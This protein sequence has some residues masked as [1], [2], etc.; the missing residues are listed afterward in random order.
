[1]PRPH[2]PLVALS[3]GPL[4]SQPLQAREATPLEAL[5]EDAVA[6]RPLSLDQAPKLLLRPAPLLPLALEPLGDRLSAA[7]Q[8]DY[9]GV[10]PSEAPVRRPAAVRSRISDAI[11]PR[12]P[13][14]AGV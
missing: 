14:A 12:E 6:V 4:S 5:L 11:V 3:V 7:P 13:H 8:R 1:V 10:A 2:E 9:L